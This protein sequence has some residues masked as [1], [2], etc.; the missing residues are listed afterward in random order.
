MLNLMHA[1]K[2]VH[3][4]YLL[5]F[6]R[7]LDHQLQVWPVLLQSALLSLLPKMMVCMIEHLYNPTKIT[8]AVDLTEY[9]ACSSFYY[10]S[11]DWRASV[12][13]WTRQEHC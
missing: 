10:A 6:F 12:W 4:M 11:E 3:D 5:P 1:D 9:F 2:L 13:S 8:S 7:N